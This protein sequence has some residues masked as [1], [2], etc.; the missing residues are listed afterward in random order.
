M[1]SGAKDDY[2][3]NPKQRA[4]AEQ[5]L[6]TRN[7]VQSYMQAY[8]MSDYNVAASSA[9]R[10]L[11][12]AKVCRFLEEKHQEANRRVMQKLGMSREKVVSELAKLATLNIKELFDEHGHMRPIH[13]LDDDVAAAIVGIDNNGVLKI[14]KEGA[15]D[16]LMRYY[17]GY[18]RDNNQQ[19]IVINPPA[20]TKPEDAGT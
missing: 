17:G 9:T 10:L 2:G 20:V 19:R 13:E 14:A 15:L 16:K 8:D 11:R 4:F 6:L 3:M 7:G 18:E 1:K 5:Y 12:N